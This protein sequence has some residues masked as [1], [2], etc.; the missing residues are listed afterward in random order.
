MTDDAA[1]A[2]LDDGLCEQALVSAAAGRVGLRG[3]ENESEISETEADLHA[4]GRQ[5]ID[6]LVD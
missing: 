4:H 6:F 3:P 1:L 2:V 5:V